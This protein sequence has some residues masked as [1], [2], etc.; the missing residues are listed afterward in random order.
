[1]TQPDASVREEQAFVRT[2]DGV[3]ASA[4]GVCLAA[5]GT[6]ANTDPLTPVGVQ[7]ICR[8]TWSCMSS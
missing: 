6:M 2:M 4:W 5:A 8:A 3:Q 1:M 7:I